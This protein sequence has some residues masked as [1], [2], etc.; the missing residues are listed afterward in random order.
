MA[1][2]PGLLSKPTKHTAKICLLS[3]LGTGSVTCFQE[4][5]LNSVERGALTLQSESWALVW[6]F[7]HWKK[8]VTETGAQKGF[9]LSPALSSPHFLDVMS[10]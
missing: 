7:T 3:S 5:E 6:H 8:W 2:P 9:I 1:Q 4:T 10:G